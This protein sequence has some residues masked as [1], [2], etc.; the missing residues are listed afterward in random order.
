MTYTI[1]TT[2]DCKWC[3]KAVAQLTLA[4]KK[5]V[6]FN[7]AHHPEIKHLWHTMGFKTIPQI[8]HGHT[9]VGGYEDL[10]NYL[11]D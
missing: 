9:Y 5:F 1:I 10:I 7:I 11:N 8:F 6:A 2:D 3:D 4:D